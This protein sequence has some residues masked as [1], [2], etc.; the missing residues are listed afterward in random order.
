M[1]TAKIDRKTRETQ[2]G[3][4]IRLDGAGNCRISTGIA[5]LDHMLDQVGRHGRLDLE[6][7][8]AG[9]V[10]VDPHH[11]VEDCGIVLGEAIASALGDKAGIRRFGYAYA[12]LDESLSRAV[13]DLSGRPSLVYNADYARE[14]VGGLDSELFREFFGGFA[15]GG[16]ITVHIDLIRGINA[17]HQVESMFK[18]FGVALGMAI[19]LDERTGG[20]I[21][22]TKG[23]I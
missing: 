15:N 21:P 17:H 1:R 5:F 20:K 9:D 18:A 19:S 13:V 8:A 4:S 12:P 11:T 10:D 2:I 6:L 14:Q 22:S 23:K 7:T 3:G 16:K